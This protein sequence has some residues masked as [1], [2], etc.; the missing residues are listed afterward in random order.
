MTEFLQL[1]GTGIGYIVLYLVMIAGIVIIPFGVPGEFLIVIAAL[2]LSLATGGQML[3]LWV[4]AILLAL[5]IIAE[6]IEAAAGF[7]GASQA[8]G[9]IWSSF[10]AITGGI[11][12]AIAG[13]FVLP[14][15]GSILGALVGTFAGA[16]IVEY[17]RS[18]TFTA[19]NKVARGALIGRILGSIAKVF[20]GVVM[21][22][23]VT[24][25]L[26]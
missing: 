3:S 2:I 6:L 19:A 21:I 12:G 4:V 25:C 26:L 15:I 16:Y 13:S 22:V 14:I 9:S 17:Q 7:L 20:C 23:I 1:L 24:F 18:R 10:G 11:I 5:G 8:E